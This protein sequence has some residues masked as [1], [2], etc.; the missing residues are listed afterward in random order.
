MARAFGSYPKGH[1]F[2]SN[3]RYQIWPVG[4]VV[5]TR[6]FHGCNMGSNPVRVTTWKFSSAGRASAL[7]AEGHRF[8]P[9]NF[10]QHRRHSRKWVPFVVSTRKIKQGLNPAG[11]KKTSRG[12]VF[13]RRLPVGSTET[14]VVYGST[15]S[16]CLSAGAFF[17]FA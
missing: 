11:V 8:E 2:K 9:C 12:L 16:F 4:Q 10:H 6:P 15:K 17:I 3:Y 7:Q 14:I 1:W 13:S 5:K